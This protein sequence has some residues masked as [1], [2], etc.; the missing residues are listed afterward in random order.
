MKLRK[1]LEKEAKVEFVHYHLAIP[2]KWDKSYHSTQKYINKLEKSNIM[3]IK[4]PLKYIRS[5]NAVIKKG[6]VDLE[7]TLDVVRNIDKLDIFIIVSGD[8]DYVELKKYVLEKKKKILFLAF[9]ENIAW[10]LKQGKYLLLN[11]IRKYI[12]LSNKKTPGYDPRRLLLPI[13]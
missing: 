10:E 12:E 4:K 3:L 8:S 7:I 5:G 1:L 6:D 9:R 2:A 11:N 13:L